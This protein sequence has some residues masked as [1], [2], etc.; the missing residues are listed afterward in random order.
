MPSRKR[1]TGQRRMNRKLWE[2]YLRSTPKKRGYRK[3]MNEIWK[4]QGMKEVKE[5]QLCD[6]RR[7]IEEK[8]F[9]RLKNRA[10]RIQKW[11]QQ[12][13]L[14]VTEEKYIELFG[15]ECDD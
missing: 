10:P 7:Q 1:T 11:H 8:Y 5:Q 4:Q 13:V 9:R 2:W 3:R 6:Q 15:T 14:I 12:S